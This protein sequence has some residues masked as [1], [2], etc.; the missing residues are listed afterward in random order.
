MSRRKKLTIVFV[1]IV[2]LLFI[3]SWFFNW[4]NLSKLNNK[5]T[6]LDNRYL[7]SMKSL[8]SKHTVALKEFYK[9]HGGDMS[10]LKGNLS[11]LDG[12]HSNAL[13][14][15]YRENGGNMAELKDKLLGIDDKHSEA[16]T[17]F[18]KENNGIMTNMSKNLTGLDS[19]HSK[20]LR[21]FNKE[22]LAQLALLENGLDNI[23]D[24][25]ENAL[26]EVYKE[27]DDN[28]TSID[29]KHSF[30]LKNVYQES[31]SKLTD[32]SNDLDN[33]IIQTE[34]KL[35]ETLNKL[36]ASNNSSLKDA[37]KMISDSNNNTFTMIKKVIKEI[38]RELLDIKEMTP[39]V[40]PPPPYE[41]FAPGISTSTPVNDGGGGNLIYLDRH[42]L[43][44]VD[45]PL[46]RMYYARVGDNFKYEY[47]C[48]S[49]GKLNKPFNK[50]TNG[51]DWGGGNTIFLDR[52]DADCG[53]NSVMT[54]LH[55]Y[56]PQWNQ[57]AWDYSCATNSQDKKL[58]CRK[59]AT[60]FNSD[61]NGNTIFLDR[62]NIKC[63]ANE[64]LSQVKLV[65]NPQNH[66]QYRFEYTCCS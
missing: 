41:P 42:N 9:E 62:H 45:K 50:V 6:V 14:D 40:P 52:H 46:N 18:Y 60:P 24:K 26:K 59:D 64:G 58:T 48:A 27:Q 19:K 3:L 12:K 23:D 51:N 36:D 15:F 32:S 2:F 54:R 65:R 49:G 53:T 13:I 56:R 37:I 38:E 11:Q 25:H 63:N 16:L 28:M 43:D 55:L 30:A 33:N 10:K 47:T 44:C 57:V 20:A 21:E 31:L 39:V 5:L 17:E 66:S 22:N 29:E 34:L 7:K 35:N 8:D 1:V 61:G 4:Q